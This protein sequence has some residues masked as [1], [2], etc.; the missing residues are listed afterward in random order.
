MKRSFIEKISELRAL[1]HSQNIEDA[2]KALSFLFDLNDSDLEEELLAGT[3]YEKKPGGGGFSD[4]SITRNAFFSSSEPVPS[5]GLEGNLWV[6]LISVLG[7]SQCRTAV[8]LRKEIKSLSFFGCYMPYL[9]PE[10]GKFT[11][12]E[13]LIINNF[14]PPAFE[15]EE[16][17]PAPLPPEIGNLKKLKWLDMSQNRGLAPPPEIGRL[18][19]LK[20]FLMSAN[21]VTEIP[22]EIWTLKK[23]HTLNLE[24]NRL[25]SVSEKIEN[26]TELRTLKLLGN[27]LKTLPPQI[28]RLE[29][30]Q[31][32]E[33]MYNPLESLP[34]EM[35]NL[36]KLK[37][38]YLV[39][40]RLKEF[41]PFLR[42][43]K[44]TARMEE[45]F[46]PWLEGDI[47]LQIQNFFAEEIRS[48]DDPTLKFLNLGSFGYPK[49]AA[50]WKNLILCTT[51]AHI[52]LWEAEKFDLLW[53][54]SAEAADILCFSRDGSFFLCASDKKFIRR[55]DISQNKGNL[56]WEI[57]TENVPTALSV[58]QD[59]NTFSVC[60]Y[61]C[62]GDVFIRK[63]SD[64]HLEKTFKEKDIAPDYDGYGFDILAFSQDGKILTAG[65]S[66]FGKIRHW[67][68][69]TGNV[70]KHPEDMG[71]YLSSVNY[72]VCGKYMIT[73][74][75]EDT[76]TVWK[77]GKWKKL[78]SF[79]DS[80]NIASII[81]VHP[82]DGNIF[83]SAAFDVM[84]IWNIET[85][86]QINEFTLPDNDYSIGKISF[87]ENQFICAL[88]Q[89][90]GHV[91][92]K[93]GSSF[94]ILSYLR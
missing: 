15:S 30:L 94:I 25:T 40:T 66:Y 1:F 55:Y 91:E 35:E 27:Q 81:S 61:D 56:I 8:S 21:I 70:L 20:T 84:H 9:P 31:E 64:G 69:D 83:A 16:I 22:E 58:S 87:S 86:E 32:L 85:K 18:T 77:T 51:D 42:K 39:N 38:F 88:V 7:R 17:K 34:D 82:K 11:N 92:Q 28:G 6:G 48:F 63:C 3:L 26:L 73:G 12:L 67:E 53:Q 54:T 65:D 23:L 90:V 78:M 44:K 59:G 68:L 93:T 49:T 46:F 19:N 45:D 29:K 80:L 72:S 33:I 41:P 43:L 37:S 89:Y 13:I 50:V 60:L 24:N 47:P 75:S 5:D 4:W 76:G 14:I 52:L 74:S 57:E 71:K 10:I 2:E 62:P 36:K 79:E